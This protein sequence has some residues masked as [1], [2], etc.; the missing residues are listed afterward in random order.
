M[1]RKMPAI[2]GNNGFTLIEVMM[3]LVIFAFGILAVGLMQI[4][5]IQGNDTAFEFTEAMA[6]GQGKIDTLTALPYDDPLLAD[7]DGDGT[8]G[9]LGLNDNTA[10]TADGSET[11]D[12]KYTLFW[13]VA[14]DQPVNS[15][16]K[17]R[18]IVQWNQGSTRRQVAL[19][20]VKLQ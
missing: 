12:A 14:A 8:G 16:R 11:I 7:S 5:A 10:S 20:T 13:N 6:L 19:D 18:V 1:N 3:A 15:A 4:T 17:I 2:P 9:D